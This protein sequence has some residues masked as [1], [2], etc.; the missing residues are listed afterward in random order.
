MTDKVVLTIDLT[1][2]NRQRIEDLP[3][4]EATMR[5]VIIYWRWWN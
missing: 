2:E 4:V 3:I 5:P 1:P